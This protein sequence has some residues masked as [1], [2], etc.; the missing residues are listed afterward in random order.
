MGDN[1][2]SKIYVRTKHKNA[3]K[4]GV[5]SEVIE[6]EK[7]TSSEKLIQKIKNLNEDDNVH[8]ILVQLPLPEPLNAWEILDHILCQ[9]G[10]N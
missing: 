7:T 6:Y 2:A 10:N 5:Q 8:G 4:H 3:A 9:M 1:P